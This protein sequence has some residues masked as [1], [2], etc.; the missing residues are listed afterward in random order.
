MNTNILKKAGFGKE[1]ERVAKNQCPFCGE[2]I[3]ESKFKDVLSLKEY[4]NSGLCQVCQDKM[5]GE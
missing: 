2:Y 4:T 5:F 1:V 3:D